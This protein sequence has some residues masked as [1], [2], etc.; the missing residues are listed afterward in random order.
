MSFRFRAEIFVITVCVSLRLRDGRIYPLETR[1]S[2][3]GADVVSFELFQPTPANVVLLSSLNPIED[4]PI[5]D[6]SLVPGTWFMVGGSSP[7]FRFFPL[8]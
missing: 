2:A 8:T 4:T 1:P 6:L 3:D 7:L 5:H